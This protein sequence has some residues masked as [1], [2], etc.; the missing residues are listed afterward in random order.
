MKKLSIKTKIMIWFTAALLLI[1]ACTSAVNFSISREVLNKS[2]QERLITAVSANAQEIEFYNSSSEEQEPQDFFLSYNGGTLEID[3][4]FLDYNEGVFTALVDSQNNLIYG[5][6]P[7]QLNEQEAF[8]FTSVGTLKRNGEKFYIYEKKLS[9]NNLDGLWLRGF[10]SESENTNVLYNMVRILLWLAPVITVAAVLGGYIIT[11]KSFMPIKTI[12]SAAREITESGDLSKRINIW[13]EESFKDG[14]FKSGKDEIQNLAITFNQMFDRLESSFESEKQF[15]SDA[16]HELR[17][18]LSVIKANCEY[19]LKHG[20]TCE[21]FVDVLQTID[22]QTDRAS[23]LLNQL[24][25]FARLNQKK[26]EITLSKLNLSTLVDSVCKDRQIL[27]KRGLNLKT[28]IATKIFVYANES[29]I[30]RLLNNLI[31]NAVKYI[32][33]G[34]TVQVSLY[35]NENSVFLSVKDDGIGI[36]PENMDKI[37]NRFYMEDSSRS[38]TAENSF[39]LGLSMVK[40]IAALHNGRMEVISKQESG[41]TFTLILP[42]SFNDDNI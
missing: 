8:S 24:L 5:E 27:L 30:T 26:A 10:I 34:T 1:S 39:G 37:W 22:R 38:E 19:A 3:D 15:T 4:D 32:G 25:F 11:R 16:S 13:G 33:N 18:P 29:L 36:S 17:T 31:D 40:E 23:L 28:D 20:N 6:M 42:L 21:D 9:G 14:N 35:R 7:I 2:I 41:S 12:D